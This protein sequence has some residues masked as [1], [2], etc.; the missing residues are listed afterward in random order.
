M[1]YSMTGF[2][3]AELSESDKKFTVEIK[4]V[5]HK[6]FDLNIRMPRKFNLFESNIRNLLKEYASRGKIDLYISYEDLSESGTSLKYNKALA[7]EYYHFYKQ[8]QEDFNIDDD[9]RT[10]TIA[11]STDVLVLEEQEINEEEMWSLLERPLKEAFS[12]FRSAREKEGEALKQNILGKLDEMQGHAAF[13]EE[14]LPQII[15]EYR[16]KLTERVKELLENSQIDEGR[17][18]AEVTM[19]ADKIAIDEELVRLSTHIRHMK[20]ILEKGGESGRNLDFIAQE[21]NRESNTILSKSNDID[22]TNRGIELKTCIEKIREQVQ[23][24]E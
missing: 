23:N 17:I 4:S 14:R 2:G 19:Y 21:M 18:A 1:I 5:N 6:Y 15:S 11:R 12:A 8:I 24:L 7:Q 13:I 9:I 10:S 20:D 3:R 22:I 16:E